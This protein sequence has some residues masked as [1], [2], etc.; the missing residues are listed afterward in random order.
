MQNKKGKKAKKKKLAKKLTSIIE[1]N[2][3]ES[4]EKNDDVFT[5]S[6]NDKEYF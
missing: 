3:S 6:Y 1:E 5:F 4:Y 2:C